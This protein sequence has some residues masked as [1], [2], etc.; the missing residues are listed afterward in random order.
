MGCGWLFGFGG[1]DAFFLVLVV[2]GLVFGVL[3]FGVLFFCLLCVLY[4]GCLCGVGC[5]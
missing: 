4:F 1:C 2:G 3:M 5:C